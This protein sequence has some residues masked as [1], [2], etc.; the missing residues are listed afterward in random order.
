MTILQDFEKKRE[1]VIHHSVI[2]DNDYEVTD[3]MLSIPQETYK[4]W[5]HNRPH[6]FAKVN[7][8]SAER[9]EIIKANIILLLKYKNRLVRQPD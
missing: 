4:C 2:K 6:V 7:K 1:T 3:G 8:R 5:F 9:A